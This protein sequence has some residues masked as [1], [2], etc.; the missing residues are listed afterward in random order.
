MSTLA[1]STSSATPPLGRSLKAANKPRGTHALKADA[2]VVEALGYLD[3]NDPKRASTLCQR[4][5]NV[6]PGHY[7]ALHVLAQSQLI[8]GQAEGCLQT[9]AQILAHHPHDAVALNNRG[10]ALDALQRLEEAVETYRLAC[11]ADPSFR[12]ARQNMALALDKIGRHEE[13]EEAY[14]QV[15][16]R[17]PVDAEA[18]YGL[19]NALCN[20]RRN[21]EA[22]DCFRQAVACRP[23][24]GLAWFNLGN[25]LL[26][27]K[28]W[29]EAIEA[30]GQSSTLLPD[31][32]A[33][34]N[35]CANAFNALRQHE[36]AIDL[37]EAAV[38]CQ[39]TFV[40]AH[41]NKAVIFNLIGRYL[42]S[43]E[44]CN[45]V[46]ELKP[47]HPKVMNV[48]GVALAGIKHH[49]AAVDAFERAVEQSPDQVE[50]WSNMAGSFEMLQKHEDAI[51]C[52]R[53]AMQ[54]KPDYPHLRGR[55]AYKQL[56][57]CDWSDSIDVI[58]TLLPR[59]DDGT[60]CDP[61]RIIAFSSDAALHRRVSES[62]AANLPEPALDL[63]PAPLPP[64]HKRI[65]VGYFSA[66]YHLHATALL[67]ARMFELH[68][69]DRFEIYAFSFGPDRK[70]AMYERLHKAFDHWIDVRAMDDVS[71]VRMARELEL[72]IAVDLKGY[73]LD[74]RIGIF[75]MR[76][77][78]VQVSYLGFP[79]TMGCPFI[80]YIVA[81]KTLIPSGLR[82][83]YTENVIYL[84]NSYQ[85]NDD[86]REVAPK[87]FTRAELGLPETGFVFCSFNN[88]YK[89]LPEVFD[90]WMRLL[91][92]VPG[93]VLWL[94][95]DS[96]FVMH[97][98]RREAEARGVDPHRLVFAPR[99]SATEHL[100]RQRVADLFLD[101][102]PCNAHT[103]ASD[104]LWVGLPVLTCSGEAFA[105]RVAA[106][107]LKAQGLSDLIA[108]SLEDYESK[109]LALALDK[110]Q[111][112]VTR[113]RCEQ[114]VTAGSL[115][116]SELTTKALEEAYSAAHGYAR[117]GQAPQDIDLYAPSR[118][119]VTRRNT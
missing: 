79:G 4:A 43:I 86:T 42:Q 110:D 62:W 108:D 27:L 38:V 119:G 49:V 90:I 97:N 70:D 19:G 48:L 11:R 21:Q 33:T 81:D 54:L 63:G 6:M 88:N 34:Y 111:M 71:V 29:E 23:D 58:N 117:L 52:Y 46:L 73:T 75:Q 3:R 84:P 16:V 78:P 115:F 100:A 94:L 36:Q 59:A 9:T 55:L 98:L 72:D 17:H 64:A 28:R 83:H 112:Q 5:L 61:F 77:A 13:A 20:L 76:A 102:L 106:S 113:A 105:S 25:T 7:E 68:D 85:I 56:Y 82:H 26:E 50:A 66:D 89:I 35:N 92:A 107:L 104:A 103:T 51:R 57:V 45:Q 109:A 10:V 93:S 47:D 37:Y 91:T 53:E 118:D 60:S 96:D 1:A 15:L 39:P 30:Y 24:F 87:A 2:W 67:A 32:A 116:R 95:K 74:H 22:V 114:A 18:H 31:H 40:E 41:F 14:R 99:A 12:D 65:R 69:K 101:T 8:L 80:D 44:A